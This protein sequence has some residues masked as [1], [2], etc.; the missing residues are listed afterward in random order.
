MSAVEKHYQELQKRYDKEESDRVHY[1]EELAKTQEK[2]TDLAESYQEAKAALDQA[3]E[4]L[5]RLAG[6]SSRA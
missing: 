2:A 1:Q 6:S 4:R 3:K 5:K